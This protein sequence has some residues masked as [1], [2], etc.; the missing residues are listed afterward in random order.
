MTAR[1]RCGTCSHLSS[2]MSV[3]LLGKGSSAPEVEALADLGM[4]VEHTL[5]SDIGEGCIEPHLA[6]RASPIS[7]GHSDLSTPNGDKMRQD[8][9]AT[10]RT[11]EAD[12]AVAS[13]RRE[14][15]SLSD[16]IALRHL[17]HS[18]TCVAHSTFS[19]RPSSHFR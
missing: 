8:A 12:L 1:S 13:V 6:N 19:P 15:S 7:Y 5:A 9:T 17:A 3:T 10:A 11:P 4:L 2:S 18:R 16:W 14:T